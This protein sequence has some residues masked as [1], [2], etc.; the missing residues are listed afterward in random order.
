MRGWLPRTLRLRLTLWSVAVTLVVVGVYALAVY[1]LVQRNAS[2]A[3]DALLRGDLRW[4]TD[5]A[6]P[7]AD[8]ALDWFDGDEWSEESPWLQ[9]FTTD[10]ELVYRTALAR[11]L[12]VPESEALAR[13]ASDQ[14]MS[15]PTAGA[16]FR[17]L[18]R[19]TRVAGQMVIVQVGRSEALMRRELGEL[20]LVLLVGLPL[21]VA[22]AALGGY[23]LARRALAPVDRMV[24]RVSAIT[25][26]RLNE[27]LPVD[28]P[29]SEL[30]RLAV[31]FNTMLG[32]LEASFAQMRRFAGDVSH[33][34]RT[35]LTAIRSVGEVA[36]REPRDEAAYRTVVGSML[37]EADRLA[38]LTD[39]LLLLSRAES[40]RI[41]LS[42]Q[43]V[44]LAALADDVTGQLG[45]LA[46]EKGQALTV[47][48]EGQPSCLGDVVVLRQAVLN[49]VD[50]AIKYTPEGGT[51]QVTAGQVNGHA[52]LEVSDT[53]PGIPAS[54]RSAMF[55]RFD[56]GGRAEGG[57]GVG[58]G[59]AIAKWAV[60]AN[61]GELSYLAA[62]PAGSTFRMS[63]PGLAPRHR[64]A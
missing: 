7:R 21:G 20:G 13:M 29:E 18:A 15:V 52:R 3:L 4:A 35:P 60:E 48:H 1:L 41:S 22:A 25:A 49:L 56:R 47:S 57:D 46:E 12:P 50:N 37:E 34:L 5:M 55:D 28:T 43:P 39:R 16:P 53:G 10:G 6:E 33:E 27:R 9:V 61:R 64:R 62:E 24:D 2:D 58:L 11:R 51:I 63:F 32:R 45:V 26:S 19:E 36:L 38:H 42:R 54:R 59:L 8:G 17:L 40:A 31:V 23:S 30:G 44:D 14:V